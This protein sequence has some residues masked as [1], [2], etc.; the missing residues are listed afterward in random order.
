MEDENKQVNE[1]T[2]IGESWWVGPLIQF[3]EFIIAVI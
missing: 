1:S 3:I 2:W